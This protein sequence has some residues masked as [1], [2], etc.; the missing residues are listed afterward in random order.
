MTQEVAVAA[1]G[2]SCGSSVNTVQGRAKSG[3]VWP[4][5]RKRKKMHL[6]IYAN[7]SE[8]VEKESEEASMA[9]HTVSDEQLVANV[10]YGK[11]I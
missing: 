9:K 7:S 1:M 10:E 2:D 4:W 8:R 11:I 6:P 5:G 3:G